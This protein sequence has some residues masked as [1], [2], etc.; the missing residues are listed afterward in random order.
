MTKYLISKERISVVFVLLNQS[1]ILLDHQMS[2]KGILKM[3]IADLV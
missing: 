1:V 3:Y 2:G